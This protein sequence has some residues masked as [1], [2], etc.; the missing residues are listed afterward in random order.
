MKLPWED[1]I[2]KN[3]DLAQYKTSNVSN[4]VRL[5]CKKQGNVVQISG[6]VATIALNV[7]KG[8]PLLQNLPAELTPS[9]LFEGIAMNNSTGE[10]YRIY[11]NTDGSL[12]I[13]PVAN[14]I[15]AGQQSFINISYIV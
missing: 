2:V 6:T 15:P 13:Y 14:S 1:K 11:I 12:H 7:K 3:Y 4:I 9:A 8:G 5:I 10:I